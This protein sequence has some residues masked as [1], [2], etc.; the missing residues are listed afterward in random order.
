MVWKQLRLNFIE[1]VQEWG[2]CEDDAHLDDP[3]CL[4]FI[5]M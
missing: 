4:M 2:W 3:H 1:V 5:P